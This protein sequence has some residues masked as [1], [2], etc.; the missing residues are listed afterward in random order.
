M[1]ANVIRLAHLHVSVSDTP[2][3]LGE[4]QPK[5][6]VWALPLT[7]ASSKTGQGGV[8]PA[9]HLPCIL[10]RLITCAV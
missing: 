3:N 8:Q 1:P 2:T 4:D 10:V 6:S 9:A 7:V 5:L